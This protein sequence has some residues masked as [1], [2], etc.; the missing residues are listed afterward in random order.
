MTLTSQ[1][2]SVFISFHRLLK[3]N[4]PTPSELSNVI[5]SHSLTNK[6]LAYTAQ[7]AIAFGV[8]PIPIMVMFGFG[9]KIGDLMTEI[10][11]LSVPSLCYVIE[12]LLEMVTK[13]NPNESTQSWRVSFLENVDPSASGIGRVVLATAVARLFAYESTQPNPNNSSIIWPETSVN[14]NAMRSVTATIVQVEVPTGEGGTHSTTVDIT[15]K[16]GTQPFTMDHTQDEGTNLNIVH[17]TLN[18]T[19][20]SFFR[21]LSKSIYVILFW[22]ISAYCFL[23]AILILRPKV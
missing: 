5:D 6:D 7:A 10:A 18:T 17:H 20:A 15:N 22:S 14:T 2:Y 13:N 4:L 23:Y 1:H 8:P 9:I 12:S 11:S 3:Q 19:L 21:S 16:L